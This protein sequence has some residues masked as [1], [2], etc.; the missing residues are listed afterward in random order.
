MLQHWSNC[1]VNCEYEMTHICFPAE[2]SPHQSNV[3]AGTGTEVAK[4][5]EG[6]VLPQ[7]PADGRLATRR[8]SRELRQVL[9]RSCY[10]GRVG[11]SMERRGKADFKLHIGKT[12]RNVGA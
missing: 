10:T 2:Q 6:L 9:A 5:A 7:P 1:M 8:P 4:V 12:K 3:F 11:F